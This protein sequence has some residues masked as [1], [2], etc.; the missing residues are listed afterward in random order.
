MYSEKCGEK[1]TYN[2]L[3]L[4]HNLS[5]PLNNMNRTWVVTNISPPLSSVIIS[6][7]FTDYDE[8]MINNVEGALKDHCTIL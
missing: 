1:K 2:V 5:G 8:V 4:V 7:T 3:H 6:G